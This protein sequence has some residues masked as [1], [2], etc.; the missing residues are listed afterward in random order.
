MFT[1]ILFFNRMSFFAWRISPKA[2]YSPFLFS[3]DLNLHLSKF[4]VQSVDCEMKLKLYYRWSF[5][6]LLG[7]TAFHWKANTFCRIHTK[8]SITYFLLWNMKCL[9]VCT[10]LW[11]K[12]S[13]KALMN[14]NTC[15]AVTTSVIVKTFIQ[16]NLLDQEQGNL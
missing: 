2:F 7:C 4:T 12:C 1:V 8:I 10:Y 14:S 16:I 5:L 3:Y 13:V 15:N 11:R 9:S 6:G